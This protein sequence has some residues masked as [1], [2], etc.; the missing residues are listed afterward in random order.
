MIRSEESRFGPP[1][2]IQ[3]V[4]NFED[5]KDG[6]LKIEEALQRGPGLGASDCHFADGQLR[7]SPTSGGV[8]FSPRLGRSKQ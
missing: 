1:A 5:E 2:R 8:W 7:R 3:L 4:G 6:E